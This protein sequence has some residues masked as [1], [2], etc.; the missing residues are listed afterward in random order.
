MPSN[1]TGNSANGWSNGYTTGNQSYPLTDA[2]AYTLSLSP[3][4]TLDQGGN[5]REWNETAY[6]NKTKRGYRNGDWGVNISYTVAWEW[7]AYDPR[8]QVN[9]IGLRVGSRSSLSGDFNVNGRVDAADYVTWRQN[10]GTSADYNLWRT[11]FGKIISAS[12]TAAVE[13]SAVPEPYSFVSIL[14][15]L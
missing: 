11:Q 2:G 8:F 9:Y 13:I 1:D 6:F 3:D 12:A 4:G 5:V 14:L 15:S 10:N 7:V